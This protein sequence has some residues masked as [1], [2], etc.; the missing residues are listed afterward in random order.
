MKIGIVMGSDSDL[1]TMKKAAQVLDEFGV[2]YEM[3]IA[4][5]HRTPEE[6]KSFV[7]RLEAEG[8]AIFIAGAGAA[9]HLPGVIASFTMCPVIGVPINATA[10]KGMDALL[11][12]VQMPSGMPVATMAIDGAK[13]AA[14]FAVQIG[15]V[16]SP[17]LQKKYKEYRNA[18]AEQVKEKNQKLQSELASSK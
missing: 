8:E 11:A 2:A 3:I 14:L 6:V 15:A 7:T 1:P 5:A 18:M 12:I 13:N 10:L 17:A 9:A 16:A 4:S